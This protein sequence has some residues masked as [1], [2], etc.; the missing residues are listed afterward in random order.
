MKDI[1]QIPEDILYLVHITK[2]GYKDENGNLIWT[3]LQASGTDQYP[4]V[5]FTLITK[6][7]RLTE[8]LFYGKNILIFSRN[9]LKQF[10]YH[11]NVSDNNGFITENNTYFPWNLEQAVKKIKENASLPENEDEV[12]YHRMNEAVFHDPVPMEYLCMDILNK[13]G[14]QVLPDYPIENDVKPNM[15][16]LPFYCFAQPEEN[17]RLTSSPE[18]FKKIAEFCG[19][20]QTLSKDEIIEKIRKKMPFLQSHRDKQN[21]QMLKN[22]YK[23]YVY[24]HRKF[25]AGSKKITKKNKRRI[26]Y[27]KKTYRRRNPN[28]RFKKRAM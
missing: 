21:I 5:Y 8:K 13:G 11:I 9:L 6:D 4:G 26:Q 12:N 10:D 18:F 27:K 7:N 2:D 28:Y 19:V 25:K 15:S 23:H 24:S 17:N 1:I 16:L 14:N 20:D 22:I 3:E